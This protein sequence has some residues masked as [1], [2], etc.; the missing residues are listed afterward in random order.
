MEGGR[1]W[2]EQ[3]LESMYCFL[4]LLWS[5]AD[6]LGPVAVSTGRRVV[7]APHRVLSVRTA[8]TKPARDRC[9]DTLGRWCARP[10]APR[11]S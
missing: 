2:R 6:A 3:R 4:V 5:T 10:I 11:P 1:G 9:R 8:T 7:V